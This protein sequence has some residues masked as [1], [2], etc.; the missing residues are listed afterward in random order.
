MA[1]GTAPV[2]LAALG[3]ELMGRKPEEI[4]SIVSGQRAGLGTMNYRSL[5]LREIAVS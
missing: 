4:G 2:A 3:A 1:A 5:S